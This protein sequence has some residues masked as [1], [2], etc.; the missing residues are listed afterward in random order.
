M[1]NK[2]HERALRLMVNDHT[3]DFD[4]L[5]QN[6]NDACNHHSSVQT[7]VVENYKIESNLNP[8]NIGFKSER[9]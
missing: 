2:I 1:I 9:R 4:A 5:L 6:N 3:N 7:L 8:P